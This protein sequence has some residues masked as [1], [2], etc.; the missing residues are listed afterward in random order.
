LR[1]Y[2]SEM[3]RAPWE[4]PGSATVWGLRLLGLALWLAVTLLLLHFF[5]SPFARAASSEATLTTTAA[6]ALSVLT[7]F[8]AATRSWLWSRR[9]FPSRR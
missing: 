4:A 3:R 2:L 6:G 8:L 1:L 5:G 9:P 7:L